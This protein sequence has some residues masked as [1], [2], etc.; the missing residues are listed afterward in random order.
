MASFWFEGEVDNDYAGTSV[1]NAGDVDGDGKADLLIGADQADPPSRANGGKAYLLSSASFAAADAADGTVD[2]AVDLANIAGLSGCYIFLGPEGGA[3]TGWSVAS[4]GDVDGDGKADILIGA[5]NADVPVA[6]AGSTFL[7]FSSALAAADAADSSVDGVIDLAGLAGVAG[8]YRINGKL[9]DDDSGYVVGSAGDVDGD[10]KDDLLIGSHLSDANGS[11][12]GEVSLL[13][14]AN[15]AAADAADGTTDGVISLSNVAAQ[16]TS[17]DI[18]AAASK[19]IGTA[20][21][22]L[23]D[24]DGNGKDDF[25]LG[26]EGNSGTNVGYAYLILGESLSAL[27]TGDGGTDG[28]ILIDATTLPPGNYRFVGDVSLGHA[29]AS[30]AVAG[31][32][33]GDGKVDILIGSQ[34]GVVDDGFAYLIATDQLAALD[35]ADATT[36]GEI[37]LGLVNGIAGCYVFRGGTGAWAGFAVSSAGDVDGDGR[38]DIIISAVLAENPNQSNVASG[39]TY[40]IL[41]SELEN[42]DAADGTDD[43][44]IVLTN[45]PGT[46]DCYAFYSSEFADRT[47]FSLTALGDLDGDGK[48]EFVVG[49]R[50][51]DESLASGKNG[52][53][54]IVSSRDMAAA[55]A[56]DGAVD[57]QVDLNRLAKVQFGVELTGGSSADKFK[58]GGGNDKLLGMDGDDDLKGEDGDDEIDGGSG[59]DK[60]D[61]GK[62]NDDL[63]GGDDDD[64]IKGGDGDDKIDGGSGKDTIDGGKDKDDLKG[65]GD[66]D[67]VKGGDGDD[68]IDGG[69][70]KDKIDG[71]N[72]KDDVKGGSGND[73]IKGG[74][75]KDKA[76]GGTGNDKIDGGK[77]NDDLK[78]G[79]GD[80]DIKGGSGNDKADGGKDNDKLDGGA[81]ND[82][83]EGGQGNDKL[84]GGKGNDQSWGGAG[85]DEFVYA[86]N[87]GV[88]IIRDYQDGLDRINLKAFKFASK[89]QALSH[90]REVGTANDDVCEFSFKG[91]K[92]TIIG[93]DLGNIG[94]SDI[95]I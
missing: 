19:R 56:L 66:D 58:G 71:G 33:S 80:D 42:L 61:G 36:D 89:A 92:V 51:G 15:I 16:S 17:F 12:S 46:G 93:A 85:S 60:I 6:N 22:S 76:D 40:L 11:Q 55:D 73:D 21:A 53:T 9:A 79:K 47:G 67:D 75:G 27:D 78:G 48:S 3:A 81:D 4:A 29:G 95:I 45:V 39:A 13:T 28:Q 54:F 18:A 90:F 65:G 74:D 88:D 14:A 77:E 82:K 68:K 2:G 50:F 52:V 10:L 23:G 44:K 72:G 26:A 70:G 49:V 43:N 20:L 87:D 38:A 5:H 24:L 25:L 32:V 30:L 91:T 8:A 84:I 1:A 31:D 64:D 86:P 41:A 57:G 83:L 94:A 69:S 35:A 7:I 63:K 34:P 62:D 59:K 37:D